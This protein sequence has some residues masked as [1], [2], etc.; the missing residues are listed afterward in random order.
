[1][2]PGVPRRV[3]FYSQGSSSSVAV[4]DSQNRGEE[5][6]NVLLSGLW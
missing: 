2:L 5:G 1:M 4:I 3:C 6:D